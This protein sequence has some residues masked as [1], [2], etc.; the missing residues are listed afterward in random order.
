MS[1]GV[2]DR[3]SKTGAATH[4]QCRLWVI[5]CGAIQPPSRPLSVVS[6]TATLVLQCSEWREVPL[7]TWRSK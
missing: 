2:A 4:T 1:E 7:A 3:M 5:R 6:P